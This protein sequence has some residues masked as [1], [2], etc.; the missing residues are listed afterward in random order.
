VTI[1][2]FDPFSGISGDMTLGALVGVGLEPDWLRALPGRL[3]L[4]DV[5]VRVE[6]VVRGE[7]AVQ[8]GGF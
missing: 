7:I 5:A 8:Q 6:Q 3:G 4:D 2:I 1:A